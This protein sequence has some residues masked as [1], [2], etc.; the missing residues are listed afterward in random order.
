MTAWLDIL[1][2]SLA[3]GYKGTFDGVEPNNVHFKN[4]EHFTFKT[5]AMARRCNQKTGAA[6]TSR[7]RRQQDILRSG[8]GLDQINGGAGFDDLGVNLTASRRRSSSTPNIFTFLGG[9][10]DREG[11]GV[12]CADHRLRR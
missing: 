7:W 12:Q 3:A 8:K 10:P 4:I 1:T 6:T 5:S 2:G 11:R 9:S